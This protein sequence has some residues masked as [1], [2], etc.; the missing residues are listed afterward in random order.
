[1]GGGG[2]GV[3]CKH[4]Q[5]IGAV[6]HFCSGSSVQLNQMSDGTTV[7]RGLLWP[8]EEEEHV[9]LNQGGDEDGSVCVEPINACDD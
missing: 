9:N 4:N 8:P 7:A 2:G 6:T 1:M 3:G 5:C